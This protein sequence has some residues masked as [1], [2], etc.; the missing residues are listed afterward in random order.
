MSTNVKTF[1]LY[2]TALTAARYNKSTYIADTSVGPTLSG[3]AL[4]RS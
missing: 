1:P 2:P 3:Y 4:R